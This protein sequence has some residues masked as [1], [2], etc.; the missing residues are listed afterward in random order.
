V[1]VHVLVQGLDWPQRLIRACLAQAL[2][3]PFAAPAMHVALTD[4][5]GM[6]EQVR[7]ARRQVRLEG[8]QRPL[9]ALT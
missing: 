4:L 3:T 6:D 8:V 2:C 9:V 1:G 7:R 5:S